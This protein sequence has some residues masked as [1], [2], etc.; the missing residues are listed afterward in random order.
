MDENFTLKSNQKNQK[1]MEKI[2]EKI[3]KGA[4][5]LNEYFSA[6]SI[7]YSKTSDFEFEYK[8]TCV[9]NRLL[10]DFVCLNDFRNYHNYELN[11][12]DIIQII[13]IETKLFIT[14]AKNLKSKSK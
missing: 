10:I 13:L 6:L 3:N 4:N 9:L 5:Y 2:I 11:V 7:L 1:E 12:H 8:L 14:I